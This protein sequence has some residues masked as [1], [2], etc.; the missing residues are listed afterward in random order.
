MLTLFFYLTPCWAEVLSGQVTD[1]IDGDTFILMDDAYQTHTVR[2]LGIDAPEF[3]QAYGKASKYSL[4]ALIAMQSVSVKTT[5]QDQY[6]R[7]LGKVFLAGED[8]GLT[9][10]KRGM[11][12]HYKGAKKSRKDADFALYAQA[13]KEAK[14]EKIGLCQD[15][16]PQSP[17]RWRHNQKRPKAE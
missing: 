8:I 10:I 14:A 6:Q 1:V 15:A 2:I 5:K 13:H 12:W 4:D 11:A 16:K 7:A 17:A 9:Q 3:H